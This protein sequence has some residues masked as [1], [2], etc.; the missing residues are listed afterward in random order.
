MSAK[1]KLLVLHKRLYVSKK[2]H[3]F[4]SRIGPL[5]WVNLILESDLLS[6]TNYPC[7][8][9]YNNCF[10]WKN[11]HMGF[12]EQKNPLKSSLVKLV[13]LGFIFKYYRNILMRHNLVFFSWFEGNCSFLHDLGSMNKSNEE[14]NYRTLFNWKILINSMDKNFKN[15]NLVTEAFFEGLFILPDPCDLWIQKKEGLC[16]FLSYLCRFYPMVEYVCRNLYRE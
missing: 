4:L 15:S 10:H 11:L 6:V 7:N 3:L 2:T 16:C 14:N 13:L 8:T 5:K 12:D 1:G 9:V